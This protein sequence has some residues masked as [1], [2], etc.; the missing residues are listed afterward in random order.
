MYY[1]SIEYQCPYCGEPGATDLTPEQ[2]GHDF[3][4]DCHVCCRPIKLTIVGDDDS[5]YVN[6]QREN[7]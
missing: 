6:A 1:E 3:I 5:Y 7:G 2:T 4:E